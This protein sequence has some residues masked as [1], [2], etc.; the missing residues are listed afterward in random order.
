MYTSTWQDNFSIDLTEGVVYW[1]TVL[2]T[3][4]RVVYW[5][6]LWVVEQVSR[7]FEQGD[8]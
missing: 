6:T 4:D 5:H 8:E 2:F 1:L 3:G 7:N